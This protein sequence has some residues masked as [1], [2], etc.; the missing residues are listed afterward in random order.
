LKL[1]VESFQNS[2]V[3][4]IPPK[5]SESRRI[6]RVM[7][8]RWVV[9]F[10][11]VI[12]VAAILL[13]AF[14][15]F[16]AP[17]NPVKQSLSEVLQQPST[18][19]LFGTDWLGRDLLSRVIYGTRISLVVGAL[20]VTIA[21][22]IGI[23]LGL[24]AG[25]F[26][27]WVN[28]IIMRIMDTMLSLPPLV[29]ALI[30]SAILG[31]GLKNLILSLGIAMVPAYCR[32]MCGQVISIKTTDYVVSARCMG[33]DHMR[34]M[35]RHLLPNAFAPLLVLITL[36]IGTAVL[37][38]A[39][40][41]Y[42]GFGILPPT[43]AWGSMVSQGYKYLLSNPLLSFA[44]GISIILLV[45]SFNLVGDGLRDALDPRLRGTI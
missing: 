31:N 34:I 19:H 17:Y 8:N 29:L 40:L 38:E 24:I 43:A 33:A 1:E 6:F 18:S 39:G 12:I 44:P 22:I 20:A 27:G 2:T 36:N 13:A 14:A 42:L 16:I 9:I 3:S 21:S 45:L 41:S 26:G 25:Y 4:T 11:A 30:I 32:L 37:A 28:T 15:P 5:V 10:G 23:T 7:F 35:L